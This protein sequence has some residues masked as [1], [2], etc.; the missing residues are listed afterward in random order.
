METIGAVLNWLT[1]LA[2]AVELVVMLY[3]TPKPMDWLTR[4][5]IDAAVVVL[6]PPFIP[7]G[8]PAVRLLRLTRGD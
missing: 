3:V 8:L 2:F 5:P 4:H 1:W 7:G 6:S